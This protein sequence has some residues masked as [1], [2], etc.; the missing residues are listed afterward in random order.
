MR[1]P[2]QNTA[3]A[4]QRAAQTVNVQS[5]QAPTGGWNARDNLADMKPNDAVELINW[6][7]TPTFLVSRDGFDGYADTLAG[8]IETLAV[9][10][11]LDGTN[12]FFA[13]SDDGSWDISSPG[14]GVATGATVTQ[15]RWY[16][17]NF[18][19]GTNNYLI[20]ANGV[21]KILYFDGST[22]LSVDSGTSPLLSGIATTSLI[23][24]EVYQS[25]LFFIQKASLSFWYLAA[26]AAGGALT[27][28][29][30]SSIAKRGGYLVAM[31]T[32][33]FDGGNGP[34]DYLVF[35]TSEGEIIVYFGTNPSVAAT[36]LLKGVYKFGT[37]LGR[38][39]LTK[40]GGDVLL[41]CQNGVLPLSIFLQSAS[42]DRQR[43]LTDKISSAFNAAQRTYGSNFGWEACFYQNQNALIFNIPIA[44]DQQADQYPMNA[45]T[46]AW[47]RFTGW[48]ANCFAVFN[49][50]LYFG[51][52][53]I[54][55]KAWTGPSD[56][57]ANIEVYGKS[58]FSYF[59]NTTQEK[60]FVLFRPMIA[61]NGPLSFLTGLDVDFNDAPIL[62]S[63]TY[64]VTA[65]ALWDVSKWDESYWAA[66]LQIQKV[67]TSPQQNVGYAAAGKI[68]IATNALTVQ[69]IASDYVY[70]RGGV[71]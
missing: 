47:T 12:A 6:W 29:D 5:Y 49:G 40:Y 24:P 4:Q 36:W 59:G 11:A 1:Q 64:S 66:S 20:L 65:G 23:Y 31:S 25:R 38:R 35:V 50:E 53:A 26:G 7:V 52:D 8:S 27:E 57:G 61:A 34:D 39:C 43:P 37:P 60:H 48:N 55:S 54:V 30:L 32:W 69:W 41:I 68:K 9:Y 28:F 63:A 71:L 13:F 62:G 15:G 67:W 51:G 19:D 14:A 22:W 46:K 56:D 21:D 17:V 33:S 42:I 2:L 10:G 3:V 45:I 18:G 58:A 16:S 70:E 44:E